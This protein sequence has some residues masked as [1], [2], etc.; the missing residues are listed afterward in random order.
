MNNQT[1][2]DALKLKRLL[3]E[4]NLIVTVE[5]F[6]CESKLKE[7]MAYSLLGGG[8]RI[9]PLLVLASAQLAGLD[10]SVVLPMAAALEMIHTYSLIHDDLPAMDNDD[11]R[12]GQPTSHKMFG[13]ALA[14]LAGDA[15]LNEAMLLLMKTYGGTPAGAK[16]MINIAQASG[17]DGMIGGQV[18]DM[19]SENEQI[20]LATLK[21]MHLGKTGALIEA[22]LTAPFYLA[23]KSKEAI[24]QM[25]AI[26]QDL[27]IMF[28]IQ[29]DILD[30]Q[31]DTATMGKTTGKDARDH[32]ATYVS[33]LGLEESW[34]LTQGCYGRIQSELSGLGEAAELLRSVTDAIYNRNH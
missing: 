13:E 30:V 1:K 12:R 2:P 22:S 34:K 29:D 21:Q 4:A 8:K 9:R 6:D 19:R 7:A 5:T 17:K 33:L 24:Q 32:K 18:L 27:G 3:I 11:L 31:S 25:A 28:Q 20:D 16:A 26:G 23:G 10:E 15:L 14:I